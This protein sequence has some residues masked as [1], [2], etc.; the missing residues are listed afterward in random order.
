MSKILV[1]EDNI[2]I[3]ENITE[4]LELDDYVVIQAENGRQGVELALSEK[5]DLIICDIMMPELD[6]YGVLHIL[7]K[8]SST[9][10]IPFIFLSA[11]ADKT[12]IRKGMTLG[13]DDYITK[14]FDD[15]ELL[16]VIEVR[17]KK[18]DAFK[19]E[20]KSD[21]D[22]LKNF[23]SDATAL[24]KML[25]I[26]GSQ[27]QVHYKKKED[28]FHNGEIPHQL[29]F[30]VS[31]KVKT[32]KMS[33]DGKELITEIYS[34]GDFFGFE[35]ILS[36]GRYTDHA[37]AFEDSTLITI[38]K[39]DFFQLIYSNKQI[40]KKFIEMLSK[41]IVQKEEDLL[42]L[43]YS[44][45][46]QRTAESLIAIHKK[47]NPN[48]EEDY[49]IKISRE[50]LSNIIG[51]ATE[52]VIRVVSEFKED[53]LVELKAGKIIIKSIPKMEQVSKWNYSKKD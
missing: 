43:A 18:V 23:I 10:N 52:T 32:Q 21:A 26:D 5:P 34:K 38:P 27:N 51:T 25:E 47:F 45:V 12:D 11:K 31:G 22:G 9:M 35:A 48:N 4:I 39:N 2:D 42:V 6:G 16:D 14:P 19:N 44:S 8:K 28:I 1:I 7:S 33:I 50:E 53:G 36:E 20:Y 37:K 46:R 17:L 24:D 40:A 49:P 15:T 41:K 29:Y 30:V 3:R 13:A